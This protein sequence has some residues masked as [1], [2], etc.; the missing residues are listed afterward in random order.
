MRIIQ[1]YWTKDNLSNPLLNDGGFLCPEYHWMSW[2]LS[3]LQLKRFYPDIELYTHQQG[4]EVLI[5]Q[6]QLPYFMTHLEIDNESFFQDCPSYLWAFA[7]IHTY[8]IQKK[9]FLHIDGDAFLWQSFSTKEIHQPLVVHHLETSMPYYKR[10]IE[11]IKQRA[12]YVPGWL[13]WNE[14]SLSA[15]AAGIIG[16]TDLSFFKEYTSEA[17]DFIKKNRTVLDTLHKHDQHINLVPEQYLCYA[18]AHQQKITVSKL[19]RQ[20]TPTKQHKELIT[21][22]AIPFDKSYIHILG[23]AKKDRVM[24]EFIRLTLKREYPEYYERIL[25]LFKKEHGLSPILQRQLAAE[26]TKTKQYFPDQV[27]TEEEKYP[28]TKR[29]CKVHHIEFN[30]TEA[31]SLPPQIEDLYQLEQGME[32][33]LLQ[34]FPKPVVKMPAF[35]LY[36]AKENPFLTK[37]YRNLY[38]C[39][40]PSHTVLESLYQWEQLLFD[41]VVEPKIDDIE[42][43][44]HYYLVS[45][46]PTLGVPVTTHLND[47]L[48]S[49]LEILKEKPVRIKTILKKA[50]PGNKQNSKKIEEDTLSVLKEW[51]TFGVLSLT[52]DKK[53]HQKLV[54]PD[55]YKNTR[56]R[57]GND[58]ISCIHYLVQ[59]FSLPYTLEDIKSVTPKSKITL[60]V[61]AT[62]LQQFGFETKGVKGTID[63]LFK[64]P[65]P[66]IGHIRLRE[67]FDLYIVIKKADTHTITIF[68]PESMRDESYSVKKFQAMWEGIILLVLPNDRTTCP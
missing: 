65:L 19:F 9:P 28:M 51:I 40:N 23:N 2:A 17:F 67:V 56:E 45:I 20:V 53:A 5:T 30:P 12:V 59:Y 49:L 54:I 58:Y 52:L 62:K 1:T 21:I 35:P 11:N 50:N 36:T 38:L 16:G 43:Y 63:S 24:C 60:H 48:L 15:Y 66:A 3:C 26:E 6:L 47:Y 33:F 68:N 34:S 32:N 57:C 55:A 4:K 27:R 22:S 64:I 7:K 18:L 31:L 29:V 13:H 25:M 14:D 37:N 42:V 61:L 41:T 8:S 39:V 44:R 10:G 46:H